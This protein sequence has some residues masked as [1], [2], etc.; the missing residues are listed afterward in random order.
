MNVKKNLLLI[1][2]A[3]LC[4]IPA[5]AK[6][7]YSDAITMSNI[8]LW[9]QAN[10]LSATMNINMGDLKV[11]KNQALVLI[12]TLING[13]N[14][15]ALQPIII[16]GEKKQKAF[17]KAVAKSG[18][19][20]NALVVPFEK[21]TDF[22]YSQVADYEPWMAEAQFVLVET[23]VDKKDRPLMTSQEV[24]TNAVSTEAKRLAELYPVVAF[25]EPPV[26]VEK[27]RVDAYN[28][29]LEFKLN[30]A[31]VL[32]KYKNNATE[33]DNIHTLFTKVL[34]DSNLVV[35]KVIIEG[36]A[37]P[38]GPEG[39]NEQLSKRR[40]EA[41]KAYLAKQNNLPA[42]MFETSFGGE[43]WEGLVTLLELSTMP[44]KDTL[45][46]IINTTT[47]DAVRKQKIKELDGG[48]PYQ[49]M[50][51]NIYPYLRN[52]TCQIVYTVAS[53]ELEQAV[54][55]MEANPALLNENEFYQVAFTN[56]R[57]TPKF[58]GAFEAALD[59]NPDSPSAN[60]NVAGAYLTKK[61]IKKAEKALKKAV[62]GSGEY[63]NNLGIINF[64]KGDYKTALACF[65]KAEFMGNKDARK[66]L[67]KW[68]D[69][70]NRNQ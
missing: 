38:E 2:L 31:Q 65:E 17:E 10:S 52:A 63:L 66:N 14:E 59:Q 49:Y 41:L 13:D 51:K 43:S 18:E 29:F 25:I 4:A 64:Y 24:I 53:L 56:K 11:D 70:I 6:K 28:T 69:A 27:I 16:N 32:P 7:F 58:I 30:Q 26:E 55:L 19:T 68:M 9:Q 33:L 46:T 40:M 1:V 34:S 50:L 48:A 21:G 62:I 57:G 12:P 39:F 60:L 5:G 20:V 37:S 23:L 61:D 36:F 42:S 35:N 44:E 22:I 67:K 8:L 45:I 47:D 54:V 15:L 3:F